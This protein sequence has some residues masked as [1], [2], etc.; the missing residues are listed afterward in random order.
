M[1][2]LTM[3]VLPF[4]DCI[5]DCDLGPACGCPHDES[6]TSW[7]PYSGTWKLPQG[8]LQ[9]AQTRSP[10]IL[11]TVRNTQKHAVLQDFEFW[12]VDL[13]CPQPIFTW[14]LD[15]VRL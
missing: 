2:V 3:R 5:K 12:Q 14:A 8:K 4:R 15:S 6:L 9:Q 13:M 1:G 7:G 11:A 10:Y